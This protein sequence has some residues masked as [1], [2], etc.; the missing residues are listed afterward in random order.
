MPFPP[1]VISIKYR[2]TSNVRSMHKISFVQKLITCI[3]AGLVIGA[4]A[5]RIGITYFRTWGT[6]G[7]FSIIP[8]LTVLFAAVYAL[9]W[10]AR[11]TNN[12]ATLAFWQGLIR[13]GVAFD[14]A[15]F[16]WAKIC[17]RQLVMPISKLDLPYN[18]LSPSDL[19]WNF[20]SYSY[21]FGCIIAALQ[22]T[23]AMLLLFHRTR[24]AG[25]FILL[26]VLANILL[27]IIIFHIGFTVVIHT[28][29]MIAGILYFLFIEFKRLKEF[30]FA[31]TNRLPQ[32]HFSRYVK[33]IIR[34]SIIY[35]PLILI[36]MNGKADKYPNLTGKYE[37]KKLSINQQ[38]QHQTPGT[39]SILTAVYFD[40]KNSCVF[41]FNSPAKRWNG[42][43][44][45]DSN[46]L[47]IK[48]FSP[49]NMTVFSGTMSTANHSRELTLTGML[50]KD[51]VDIILEKVKNL[52]K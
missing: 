45:K 34:L 24:L 4:S 49:G 33:F 1:G 48:W 52:S 18:S 26:P 29:I 35:I 9:I 51:S 47:K 36:A 14:L 21:L 16:G 8:F 31:T 44:S 2:K 15:E 7:G 39:D 22:I 10:Q 37:V 41:Q 20:F 28:S 3:L 40:I 23:G 46:H 11:K 30:F 13:Y 32:L 50:G 25:V 19:F 38:L 12:P 17:H 42:T 27:M 43:F 5:L 6:F